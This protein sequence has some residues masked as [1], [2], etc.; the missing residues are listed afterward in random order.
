MESMLQLFRAE[1]LPKAMLE[2]EDFVEPNGKISLQR[3]ETPSNRGESAVLSFVSWLTLSAPEQSGL[4]GPSTENQEA[5]QAAILCIKHCDPEKLITESKFL[6][7]ESLQELMK[8][9]D[10]EKLIT[11]SKFLQLESL[12][13]LMKVIIPLPTASI[14]IPC[15]DIR[16]P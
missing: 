11:E 14:S 1:L 3:E 2:V 9:C 16:H 12:Q 4:R 6:Q 7:L 8:Q 5:K 15:F 10:P 13:E